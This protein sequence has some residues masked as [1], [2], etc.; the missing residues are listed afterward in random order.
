[1]TAPEPQTDNDGTIRLTKVTLSNKLL[2]KDYD[3]GGITAENNG[4]QKLAPFIQAKGKLIVISDVLFESLNFVRSSGIDIQ[5]SS[6]VFNHQVII[7]RSNFQVLN[8][9]D[10]SS[11]LNSQGSTLVAKN[12]NI[13]GIKGD[14]KNKNYSPKQNAVAPETC[15][16]DTGAVNVAD[17]VGFFESTIFRDLSQGALKVGSLGIVTLKDTVRFYGNKVTDTT[18]IDKGFRR[19]IYCAG[20][21]NGQA[22]LSAS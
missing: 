14:S 17:G 12:S 5:G 8:T 10:K 3:T 4:Q 15:E 16:W 2:T 20:D 22:Q 11:F 1:I 7:E 18:E 13:F 21:A 9:G 6:G 19:N